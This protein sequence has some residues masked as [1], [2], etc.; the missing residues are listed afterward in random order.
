MDDDQVSSLQNTLQSLA[1]DMPQVRVQ[2]SQ[3]LFPALKGT[4]SLLRLCP[5]EE[6]L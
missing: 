6:I 5:Q 1:T 4:A 2:K 3:E